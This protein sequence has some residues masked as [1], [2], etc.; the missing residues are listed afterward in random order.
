MKIDLNYLYRIYRNTGQGARFY[1]LGVVKSKPS[2]QTIMSEN[3]SKRQLKKWM[4]SEME[5]DVSDK[6]TVE[7]REKVL[8]LPYY[9]D[10]QDRRRLE[11][12]ILNEEVEIPEVIV[13][14]QY[15]QKREKMRRE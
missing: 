1:K 14:T 6:I 11:E 15:N 8:V 12:S 2:L 4:D 5:V 13:Q 10:S 3:E 9:R 7:R